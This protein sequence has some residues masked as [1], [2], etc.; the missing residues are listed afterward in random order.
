MQDRLSN[1]L[2]G[3]RKKDS[4]EHCLMYIIEIKKIC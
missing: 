2:T 1:L 3:F 4:T